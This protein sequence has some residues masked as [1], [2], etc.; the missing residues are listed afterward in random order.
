MKAHALKLAVFAGFLSGLA[1]FT[2]LIAW[3]GISDVGQ[4]LA[5]AGWG[6]LLV[7]VFHLLP[8]AADTV[9]WYRLFPAGTRLPF[10]ILLGAR[11]LG[12]SI[13]GLLPVAQVG[14]DLVK[15]RLIS[16][17]GLAGSLA[18]ATVVVDLTLAVLTQLLFTLVGIALLVL[19]LGRGEVTVTVLT[20]V[21]MSG[22]LL[23]GFYLV[24][25]RGMFTALA[26]VLERIAQ[27]RD[28]ETL[29]GGAA[30]LDAAVGDLYQQRQQLAVAGLWR[31]LGWFIGAGEVWIALYF[32]G[33]PVGLLEAL[34]LESL[35][36]AVRASAFAI[37]GALGVQEGGYL[38]LGSLLGLGPEVSLALSLSKR[39]REL[40]LGLPVLV[41][42]QLHESHHLWQ[43]HAAGNR[44]K[45]KS[46]ER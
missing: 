44:V 2:L 24:Q 5:V 11:W 16:R 28:W 39:V 8:M 19:Y 46:G 23:G 21:V 17:H 35:G 7:A 1:L 41:Y 30:R 38:L 22:L 34:L 42:W 45:S 26:R 32:L 10:H 40:L 4:V 20:G 3:H 37:P 12:E 13:N 31:L 9:A 15:A 43:Q 25:R 29:I 6:L 27:G 33:Y 36:Q 18:G 14:G